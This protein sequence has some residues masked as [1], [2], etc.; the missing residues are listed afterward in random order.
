MRIAAANEVRAGETR[1]ALTPDVVPLLLRD[2]HEV[3]VESGAG[4]AAHASDERYVQAG[5]RIVGSPAELNAQADAIFRVR[6]PSDE[7]LVLMHAGTICIGLL[8][9]LAQASRTAALAH[10]GL[11]AYALELV[12]RI[13]RAQSMDA[14]TSMATIA[15]YK[16]V[17]LAADR[18]DKL[19][20][21]MMTAAGTVAPA[22]V[23]VLGAGVAGLQ[24]VATAK[25]L[26]ARVTAFDPRPAVHE[27]VHS[28][29]A[30]FLA[31]EVSE[32]AETAG[33]YAREQ[34]EA[35]LQRE[36]ASIAE[37]LPQTDVVICTAQV[38]GKHAPVLVTA[39]MLRLLRP[40]A[41]VVDLAADQGGNCELTQAGCETE[42]GGVVVIGAGNLPAL[43]PA[44][45]SQLYA[46]NL[47]NLV[48][49]LYPAK[50]SPPDTTD[51]IVRAAC[52]TRDGQI[53][54]AAVRA[55]LAAV[56]QGVPA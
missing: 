54:N 8:D 24:A 41:V 51:E 11:I 29:G 47:V 13:A 48:R 4:A 53:V 49:Y 20:P 26:G 37:Y 3:L 35:F 22:V 33:G 28:L 45:A 12:P 40:G 30:A 10:Q 46:H 21:L 38:A 17:L 7:E 1:V 36:R 42:Q 14:L 32:D 19:F 31:M 5:A 39:E 9:P 56:Q 2:G 25:R 44:D 55:A 18:L 52:V 27:Q 23:L 43:V 50:G 15:G 6:P 34:S 16:A